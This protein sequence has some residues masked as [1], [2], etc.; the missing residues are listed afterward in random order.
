LKKQKFS[1]KLLL[2]LGLSA[3]TQKIAKILIVSA[4]KSKPQL[5][6]PF[7]ACLRPRIKRFRFSQCL[8]ILR[9][10]VDAECKPHC[11]RLFVELEECT[12]RVNTLIESGQSDGKANCS[13]QLFEYLHCMDHCVRTYVATDICLSS[14]SSIRDHARLH[15]NCSRSSNSLIRRFSCTISV[16]ARTF[17]SS[18]LTVKLVLLMHFEVLWPFHMAIIHTS[19][20]DHA[21]AMSFFMHRH[22]LLPSRYLAVSIMAIKSR[23]HVVQFLSSCFI[24]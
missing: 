14:L 18:I 3:D 15:R 1:S 8:S 21:A 2:L 24:G 12:K 13:M 10:Q 4:N 23:G 19:T 20:R 16:V 5:R 6:C 7:R 9:E 22:K 11:M 17:C